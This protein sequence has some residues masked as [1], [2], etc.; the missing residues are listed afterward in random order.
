MRRVIRM[1]AEADLRL[2]RDPAGLPAD[3]VPTPDAP[4]PDAAVPDAVP[5]PDA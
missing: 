3:A 2:R 4:I 5:L 1:R